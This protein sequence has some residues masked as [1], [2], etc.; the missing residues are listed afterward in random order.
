M[1]TPWSWLRILL[2][3]LLPEW[4]GRRVLAAMTRRLKRELLGHATDTFLELLLAGMALAFLLLPSYRRSLH[5]CE[6]RLV[7]RCTASTVAAAAVIHND[8]FS[9]ER[10]PAGDGDCLVT[11]ATPSALMRFLF[12]KD[13]DILDSMLKSEVTVQGNVN[14]IYR[15]GF[16]ANELVYLLDIT[17]E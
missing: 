7:F 4:A 2:R 16:L 1:K 12:A 5:N 14:L 6:A 11:F 13:H 10:A 17:T 15:F 3:Y 8:A 9:V